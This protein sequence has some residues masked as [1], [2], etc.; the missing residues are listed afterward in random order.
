MIQPTRYAV[1]LQSLKPK[2]RAAILDAKELGALL[3]AIENVPR[4]A[5][6]NLGSKA[7]GVLF[8]R[9]GE[10]R[11]A[12]WKEFDLEA[13]MWIIP[14]SRTKMRREHRIPCLA[15]RSIS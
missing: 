3:R 10:L 4:T 8:P 12:E 9:P 11:L 5:D 6:Y 1:L 14:A 7:D 2:H 15:N 13:A